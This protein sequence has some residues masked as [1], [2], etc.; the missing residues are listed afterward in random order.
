MVKLSKYLHISSDE[1]IMPNHS[2]LFSTRTAAAIELKNEYVK[3]LKDGDYAQL[4]FKILEELIHTQILVPEDQDE[5]KYILEFNKA[6]VDDGDQTDLNF[7]IQPSGNCQLGCH[8]C[9]QVHTKKVASNETVDLILKRIEYKVD[10][11]KDTLKRIH[12][13]W[14]GGEPLTGLNEL[15]QISSG[16]TKLADKYHLDY[17][18]DMITNGLILKPRIFEELVRNHK[19]ASFQVTIDGTAEFH[20]VRRVLKSGEAS[21]DIIMKNIKEIVASNFYK[22]RPSRIV[23]RCNVDRTNKDN[24][25]DLMKILHEENILPHVGIYVSPIHDWGDLKNTKEA[26][27][28]SKEEFAQFEI[29]FFLVLKSYGLLRQSAILPPRITKVC[30]TTSQTSEV[31]DAFGNVSTCWEIPYT[32]AYDNSSYYAGNLHKDANIDTADSPMRKWNDEIPVNSTWCKSCKFLPV[33]GGGC[34]KSW[35]SET[36][37]CPSVKFNIDERLFLKKLLKME[38]EQEVEATEVIQGC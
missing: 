25:F 16:I 7:T 9:G 26:S 28:I 33:C 34:P 4:P 37:P 36:P 17:S 18:A 10:K 27:G 12:V 32:P 6:S 30:M 21:F 23:I 38:Q 31:L 11:Q 14:Y 35:Y 24:I 19:L 5:L 8:Y 20:D 3:L 22:S 1:E 15:I 13:T 29:D 2:I